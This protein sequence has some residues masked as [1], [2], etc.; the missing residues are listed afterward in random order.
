MPLVAVVPL[1]EVIIKTVTRLDCGSLDAIKRV[2]ATRVSQPQADSVPQSS[3]TTQMI[4]GNRNTIRMS[5]SNQGAR[6]NY[7]G[8][9]S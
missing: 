8:R 7:I 5:I 4:Y 6:G 9:R 3:R 1:V 2:D